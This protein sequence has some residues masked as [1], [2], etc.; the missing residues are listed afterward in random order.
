MSGTRLSSGEP[1]IAPELASDLVDYSEEGASP[2]SASPA[3]LGVW[4]LAWPTILSFL[5]QSLVRWVSFAMVGG[6]GADALAA[7]PAPP[8]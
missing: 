2:P 4:E 3:A 8:A 6:L 1:E 5:S 7:E